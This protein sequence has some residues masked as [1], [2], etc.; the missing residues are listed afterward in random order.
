MKVNLAEH[1]KK[2]E[3]N[4]LSNQSSPKSIYSSNIVRIKELNELTH[5][6]IDN[7]TIDDLEYL[8]EKYQDI[9]PKANIVG[10]EPFDSFLEGI[11]DDNWMSA[12]DQVKDE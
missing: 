9:Y 1:N 12:G 2:K 11:E 10:N 4:I 6:E 7:L 8:R 3:K 5:Q